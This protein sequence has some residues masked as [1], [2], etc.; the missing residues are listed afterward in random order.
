MV[1]ERARWRCEYCLSPSWVSPQPFAADHIIPFCQGGPTIL[2]NLALSC[3]CNGLK[4]DLTRARD[5]KTKRLV[6]LFIP[7]RQKW[8]QHFAWSDNH[9][10]IIGLTATGRATVEALKLNREELVNLRGALL[11]TGDHPPNNAK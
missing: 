6:P 7:R 10:H 4:R 5:P 2:E 11:L 9:L 3:G 1:T 8:S